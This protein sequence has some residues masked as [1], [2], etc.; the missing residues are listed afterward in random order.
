MAVGSEFKSS[1]ITDKTP[2]NIL[3][4]AGT[5]H[6]GLTFSSNAWN[7]AES[8]IGAT[9]GGTKF[10][11]KPE[12]TDLDIDGKLVKTKGLTVKTGETAS[13]ETNIVE[14][15]PDIMKLAIIGKAGTG[16]TATGYSEIVSKSQIE[17]GDYLEN[18][19]YVGKTIDG[20]PII[21]IFDLA[22]CTS[23]LEI[24]GKNKEAG[25]FKGTFECCAS[26]DGDF[27]KLPYHIY[28]PTQAAG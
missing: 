2:G 19:G 16:T 3:L 5:I 20:K 4:G 15:T 23:G 9:S 22:L 13:I 12:L 18:F 26:L 10:S 8:L 25:V 7:F 1:G 14:I 6:K 11:I 27:D 28:Y 17:E 24:E 21:I